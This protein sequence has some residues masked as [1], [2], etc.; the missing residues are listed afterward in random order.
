MDFSFV[1]QMC[2]DV[3]KTVIEDDIEEATFRTAQLSLRYV[4]E[5]LVHSKEKV[6]VQS[7]GIPSDKAF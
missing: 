2:G 4:L 7:F 3:P 5:T 6:S 1:W